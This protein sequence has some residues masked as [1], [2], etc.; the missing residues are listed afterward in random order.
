MTYITVCFLLP[1]YILNKQILEIVP[2]KSYPI[3]NF[4]STNQMLCLSLKPGA[5]TPVTEM[6]HISVSS[7]YLGSNSHGGWIFIRQTHQTIQV[8][9]D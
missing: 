7:S 2:V 4:Y 9:K 5:G 3:T 6:G 8:K 1:I